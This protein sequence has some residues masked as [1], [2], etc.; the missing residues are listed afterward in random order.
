L[1]WGFRWAAFT[2][3]GSG[4]PFSVTTGVDNNGDGSIS[5]RPFLNG[6][7]I[8]RNFGKG[9]PI[10]D[11]DTSL[12]K[13]LRLGE[14]ARIILRAE[15]F[16]LFNHSNFFGRSGTFGNTPAPSGTFGLPVGGIANVG[17]ARQMQFAARVQF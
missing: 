17:P 14:H 3:L 15:A 4:F 10:Y 6:A 2:T 11:V 12:Q 5:D 13:S 8:P 1:P 7:V 9:S 16:N